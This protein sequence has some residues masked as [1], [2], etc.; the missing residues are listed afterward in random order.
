MLFWDILSFL[1]KYLHSTIDNTIERTV[2]VKRQGV[3]CDQTSCLEMSSEFMENW[4]LKESKNAYSLQEIVE[5]VVECGRCV[6]GF[7]VRM[8][9]IRFDQWWFQ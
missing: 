2:L 8:E 3:S 6:C 7:N 1:S 5:I 9:H 4:F